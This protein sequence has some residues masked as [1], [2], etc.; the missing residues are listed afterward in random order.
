MQRMSSLRI[1]GYG[2]NCAS[3]GIYGGADECEDWLIN[4]ICT[5]R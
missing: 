3:E 1:V 4:L 2:F 5:F